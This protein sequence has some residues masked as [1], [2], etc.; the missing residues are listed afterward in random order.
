MLTLHVQIKWQGSVAN[1]YDIRSRNVENAK[2][3]AKKLF[4]TEFKR[5]S[6]KMEEMETELISG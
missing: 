5:L 2:N 1:Y 4:A 6:P 3:K